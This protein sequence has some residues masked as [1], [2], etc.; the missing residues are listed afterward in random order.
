MAEEIPVSLC[1]AGAAH[2][3]RAVGLPL[4]VL[5]VCDAG[6]ETEGGVVN[7]MTVKV[8]VQFAA[9]PDVSTADATTS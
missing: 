2:E 9:F 6:Q 3:M 7:V 4:S 8:N 1:I 5:L